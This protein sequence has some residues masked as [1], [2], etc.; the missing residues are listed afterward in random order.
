M[1]SLAHV[2]H[3]LYKDFVTLKKYVKKL[4]VKKKIRSLFLRKKLK[5]RHFLFF[6]K[7]NHMIIYEDFYI[8]Y[9][10]LEHSVSSLRIDSAGIIQY[11]NLKLSVK[12]GY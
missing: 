11:S 10:Y 9:L 4:Y 7:K 8:L 2:K 5:C 1:K 3:D 12:T 6:N